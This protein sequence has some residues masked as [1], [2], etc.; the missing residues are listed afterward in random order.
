[1]YNHHTVFDEEVATIITVIAETLG[2][3]Y[4]YQDHHYKNTR[5]ATSIRIIFSM[6][7]FFGI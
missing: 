5:K 6:L 1:M 7:T 2:F 4:E 3:K